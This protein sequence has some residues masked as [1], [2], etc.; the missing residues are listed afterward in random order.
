MLSSLQHSNLQTDSVGLDVRSSAVLNT[1]FNSSS[2]YDADML[3]K[4]LNTFRN[5]RGNKTALQLAMAGFVYTG[6]A[7]KVMC[8]SCGVRLYN[9]IGEEDPLEEHRKYS[10]DCSFIK[11]KFP[12]SSTESGCYVKSDSVSS[13][14]SIVP[15]FKEYASYEERLKSFAGWPLKLPSQKPSVLA[16]SGFFYI[17]SADR[18]RCFHCGLTLRDWDDDDFPPAVH[19]EW[20]ADCEIAKNLDVEK[21]RRDVEDEGFVSISGTFKKEPEMPVNMA[22]ATTVTY[23]QPADRV[24]SQATQ[25]DNSSSNYGYNPTIQ[26]VLEM[27]YSIDV[28]NKAIEK[29]KNELGSQF[30][31]AVA[32]FEA[33]L[34]QEG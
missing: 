14:S 24:V 27:G 28:I 2:S 13:N 31:N 23:A 7:D 19:R 12:T 3:S 20:S 11:A 6:S 18:A 8:N 10:S 30:P 33:V 22:D 9:W 25:E 21:I 15:K 17:G 32:L 1:D 34:D 29:R 4:R 26:A 5:Y 16:Q